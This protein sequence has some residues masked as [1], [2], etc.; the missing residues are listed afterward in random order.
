MDRNKKKINTSIW[1]FTYN[2][3]KLPNPFTY[4]ISDGWE[5][6]FACKLEKNKMYY[7]KI[8][9]TNKKTT[10]GYISSFKLNNYSYRPY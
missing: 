3:K 5:A 6:P 7:L 8:V 10:F 1:D 9:T 4:L 2:N